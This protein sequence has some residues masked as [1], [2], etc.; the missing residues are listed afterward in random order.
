MMSSPKHRK[1]F[2]KPIVLKFDSVDWACL[3][4]VY[5]DAISRKSPQSM[6]V[7]TE[8]TENEDP[9]TYDNY[10]LGNAIMLKL[11]SLKWLLGRLKEYYL[12][13]LKELFVTEILH[14]SRNPLKFFCLCV[15]FFFH[16]SLQ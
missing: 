11:R 5:E 14:E 7:D 2:Q 15:C 10:L 8:N 16:V 13:S 1:Y 9:N 12:L 3:E 4:K 6:D